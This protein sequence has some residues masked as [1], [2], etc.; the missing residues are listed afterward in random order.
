MQLLRIMFLGALI[1]RFGDITW[2]ARLPDLAVPTYFLCG[3]VK[4]NVY[5]Y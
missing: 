2:P 4:S 3:Y 5:E 1:S